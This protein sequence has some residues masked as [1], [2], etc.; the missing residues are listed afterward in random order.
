[1]LEATLS[2]SMATSSA[3]AS[4]LNTALKKA[5]QPGAPS[6]QE[7]QQ[8]ACSGDSCYGTAEGDFLFRTLQGLINMANRVIAGQ[9][10]PSGAMITV[11]GRLDPRTVQAY[12]PIAKAVGGPLA[13]FDV[14]PDAKYLAT[15][16]RGI[17]QAIAQWLN[18]TWLPASNAWGRLRAGE[19][20][21]LPTM[22]TSPGAPGGDVIDPGFPQPQPQPPQPQPQPY[23]QPQPQPQTTMVMYVCADGSRVSTPDACPVVQPTVGPG[24]NPLPPPGMTTGR[25]R[26]AGCIARYNRTRKVFAIYCPVP[27][28]TFGW[29]MGLG[30]D[31]VVTPP[32]PAGF[33]KVAEAP[34]LPNE[35]ETAAGEE[36]D[37]FFRVNNPVM[38]IAIVGAVAAVGTGGYVVYRRKRRAA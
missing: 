23:P 24:A 22:A 34:A 12:L 15:S 10:Q 26:Y 20:S 5:A 14:V 7:V 36:R 27:A 32:A 38:W 17:A 9:K 19:T 25:G 37:A 30:A 18:V 13:L 16:A 33:T 31:P 1:M 11:D 3:A 35:G 21:Q 28:T 2:P 4:R 6:I 8:F 29:A